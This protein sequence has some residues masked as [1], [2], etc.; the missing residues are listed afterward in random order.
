MGP[1]ASQHPGEPLAQPGT[2]TGDHGHPSVQ[3]E[4][5]EG[6]LRAVCGRTGRILRVGHAGI[7]RWV[8]D[9][10]PGGELHHSLGQPGDFTRVVCY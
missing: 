7:L 5:F 10:L 9:D 6:P 8:P 4:P 1:N 3:A 2:G